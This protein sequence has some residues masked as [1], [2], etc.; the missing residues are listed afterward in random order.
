MSA[1]NIILSILVVISTVFMIVTI[2]LQE[3]TSKGMG[4][5]SGGSDTYFNRNKNQTKQ[6]KLAL[7][8]KIAAAVFV[9]CS[10]VMVM[11]R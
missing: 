10:L 3:S 5:L 1:I 4:A 8:T 9:V 7:L 2:M 11:I 6:A